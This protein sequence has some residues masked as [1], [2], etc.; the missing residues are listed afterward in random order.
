MAK[1]VASDVAEKISDG[2]KLSLVNTRTESFT[3]VGGTTLVSSV[4]LGQVHCAQGLAEHCADNS[5]PEEVNR[6]PTSRP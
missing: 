5:N 3:S 1:N 6:R 4:V 2:V